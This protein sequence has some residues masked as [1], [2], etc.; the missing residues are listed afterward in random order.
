MIRNLLGI[1]SNYF[2][3]DDNYEYRIISPDLINGYFQQ[4]LK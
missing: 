3:K 1:N 4:L 2:F